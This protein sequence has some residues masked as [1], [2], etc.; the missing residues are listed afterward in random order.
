MG[1][2][3]AWPPSVA[4]RDRSITDSADDP[5][6]DPVGVILDI[7]PLAEL[8]DQDQEPGAGE[9]DINGPGRFPGGHRW[10]HVGYIIVDS[11]LE[12]HV[13]ERPGPVVQADQGLK[14]LRAWFELV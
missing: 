2:S 14:P 12:H 10:R 1:R 9:V 3:L 6:L 5:G 8:G 7:A 4:V 11:D 13:P